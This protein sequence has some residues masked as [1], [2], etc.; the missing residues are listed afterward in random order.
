[1]NFVKWLVYYCSLSLKLEYKDLF[2]EHYNGGQDVALTEI[3]TKVVAE[4]EKCPVDLKKFEARLFITYLLSY[5]KVD[6]TFFSYSCHNSK[7]SSFIWMVTNSKN[8]MSLL[9]KHE[10]S[11]LMIGLKKTIQK[12]R[13]NLSLKT[14]K[15]K[16]VMN[17]KTYQYLCEVLTN[18]GTKESI[19]ALCWLTLQWNLMNRSEATEAICFRQ[20]KWEAD[21]LKIYFPCHKS[22]P[23]GET[24]EIP[25]HVYSNPLILE[26]CPLRALSSYLM[27]FPDI[28][29]EGVRLFPGGDD[30][31]KR[32]NRLFNECLERN[33]EEFLTKLGVDYTEIDTHSIRIGTATY[34][35]SGAHPGPLIVSVC[36]RAGWSLG[37]V[38]ERY[39]K[40]EP[41]GDEVFGR[42]LTGIPSTCG[43]LTPSPVYFNSKTIIQC[44]KQLSSLIFRNHHSLMPLIEAMLASFIYHE[45]WT[46]EKYGEGSPI[47]NI[48]YWSVASTAP[49]RREFVQTPLP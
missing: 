17:W 11:N 22:D 4:E 24:K 20:L 38:K 26:V 23:K 14:T 15:G 19:F 5:K 1:M 27:V 32:F 28:L 45:S 29:N 2:K 16:D 36:L 31:K 48:A 33:S 40:Y 25:R 41:C 3:G 12:E 6:G 43:E 39:L 37:R 44:I 18:E 8:V 46:T 7:K 10:L 13:R 49:N 30:Q 47:R 21:H 9:E 35:C 34:C 42:T